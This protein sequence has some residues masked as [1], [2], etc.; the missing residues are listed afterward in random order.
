MSLQGSPR[1]NEQKGRGLPQNAEINVTSLI[2]VAFT[3]LVIFIITAPVL[4]GG[5]EVDL[6]E[7]DVEPVTQEDDPFFVSIDG[8]G[9]IYVAETP[10][11]FDEFREQ[12][13]ELVELG[14]PDRVFI[15]ADSSTEYG[16]LGPVITHVNAVSRESG[17]QWALVM[18]DEWDP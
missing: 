16:T 6:P 9:E 8:E 14:Q 10:I 4:Q 13:R 3:L 15:R 17:L 1:R 11:P 2:D 18:E 5:I 12:L 7:G